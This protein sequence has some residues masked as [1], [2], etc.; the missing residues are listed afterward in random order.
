MKFVIDG[1]V[2]EVTGV[3][4]DLVDNISG[5]T[6]GQI[7][8]KKSDGNYDTE[9][10]TANYQSLYANYLDSS[11]GWHRAFTIETNYQSG[12]AYTEFGHHFGNLRPASLFLDVTFDDY[13]PRITMQHVSFNTY[14]GT[15][16]VVIDKI[17]IVK[18]ASNR[19]GLDFHRP[20]NIN[21]NMTGSVISDRPVVPL[22]FTP[23]DEDTGG[24]FTYEVEVTGSTPSGRVLTEGDLYKRPA[25]IQIPVTASELVAHATGGNT[26]VCCEKTLDGTV[27]LYVAVAAS[28]LT[29]PITKSSIIIGTIPVGYRP[30]ATIA[31]TN[32]TFNGNNRWQGMLAYA[33][34]N[35]EIRNLTDYSYL[36]S[37]GHTSYVAYN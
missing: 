18:I 10:T 23:V 1:K 3:P 4:Q 37:I 36:Y 34:G 15:E 13:A 21:I 35:I 19:W 17:R 8:T 25:L 16:R 31:W 24:A 14:D 29:T 5:G 30:R 26:G 28:D 11:S 6:T 20:Y 7:L 22:N 12:R 33:N 2:C 9:W 27:H 32:F